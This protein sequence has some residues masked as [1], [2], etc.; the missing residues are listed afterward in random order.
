MRNRHTSVRHVA[1]ELAISE[2]SL[3]EIISDYLVMKKVCTRW[4]LKLSTPLQG[5]DRVDYCE[6]LPRNYNQVPTGSF[7]RIVTR[8]EIWIHYYDPLSQQETKT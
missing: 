4:V 6:E 7:G 1:D 5:V 8:S 3:Y 2:T